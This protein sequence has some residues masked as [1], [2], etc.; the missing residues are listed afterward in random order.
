MCPKRKELLCSHSLLPINFWLHWV[1]VAVCGLSLVAVRSA[2]ASQCSVFSFCKTHAL[3][4]EATVDVAF[5][6]SNVG[7]RVQALV[8]VWHV[9]SSSIRD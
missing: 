8:V 3:C 4:A 9:E 6:S 1:F 2:Q 7:S 5:G